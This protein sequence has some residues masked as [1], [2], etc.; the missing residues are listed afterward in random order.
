MVP[1]VYDDFEQDD[2]RLDPLALIGNGLA[3]AQLAGRR[4]S[5]T[6][7]MPNAH[8]L[9]EQ[10][11]HAPSAVVRVRPYTVPPLDVSPLA[12]S[13][14]HAQSPAPMHV[15]VPP[16]QAQ[17]PMPQAPMHAPA[18]MHAGYAHPSAGYPAPSRPRVGLQPRGRSGGR[19]VLFGLLAGVIG[20]VLL[21]VAFL[22]FF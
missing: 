8:A 11:S 4:S 22:A 20:L 10:A 1:R 18:P 17:A 9:L 19:A 15:H 5:G 6:A 13:L 3:A 2:T 7:L 21:T 12:Q 16:M 14:M